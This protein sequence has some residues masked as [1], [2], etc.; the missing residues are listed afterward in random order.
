MNYDVDN[1]KRNVNDLDNTNRNVNDLDNTNVSI[2]DVDSRNRDNDNTNVVVEGDQRNAIRDSGNANQ[3]QVRVSAGPSSENNN[4]N[5]TSVD[6]SGNSSSSS[7]ASGGRVTGSGNSSS[8]SG[9]IRQRSRWQPTKASN[10]R[11]TQPQPL[12]YNNGNNS[13][14]TS[15]SSVNNSVEMVTCLRPPS[16]PCLAVVPLV[17]W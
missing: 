16:L 5:N 1:T 10:G 15:F 8:S 3:D 4:S 2:T 7:S 11:V 13:Q 14:T 6:G 17:T 9:W 12:F